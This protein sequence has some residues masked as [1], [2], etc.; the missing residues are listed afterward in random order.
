MIRE[1][2]CKLPT[3]KDYKLGVES[4][5]EEAN[6]LQQIRVILGTKPG[7][8]LG[9]PYFGIDLQRELFT[10]D[11]NEGEM[12]LRVNTI[13]AQ[14]VRFD[15]GKYTIYADVSFGKS[16]T[17]TSDYAVIDITINERKCLGVVVNQ[18]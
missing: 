14:Y 18:N 7:E 15:P 12:L 10:M 9:S 5:D 1:I 11:F 3:D 13:L 6:I 2:Y 8:V 16:N 17:D 4:M